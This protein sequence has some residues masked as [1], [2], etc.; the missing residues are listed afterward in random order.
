MQNT[1]NLQPLASWG[2]IIGSIAI[3]GIPPSPVFISKLFL[4]I[5]VGQYSPLLLFTVLILVL[6][7]AGAF[8]FLLIRTFSR[9]K[10]EAMPKYHPLWTMKTQL[11]VFFVMIAGAGVWLYTGLGNILTQIVTGLGF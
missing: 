4:L 2:M 8:A 7:I 9:Q 5:Q 10:E 1:L 6:I 11:V 3:L